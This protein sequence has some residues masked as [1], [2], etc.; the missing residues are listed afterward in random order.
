MGNGGIQY[1]FD[2]EPRHAM[3]AG[4]QCYIRGPSDHFPDFNIGIARSF[5]SVHFAWRDFVE[6]YSRNYLVN[7]LVYGAH[8]D[9]FFNKG[10]GDGD[11]A[12]RKGFGGGD[13]EK[14]H[15][16]NDFAHLCNAQPGSNPAVHFDGS[17]QLDRDIRNDRFDRT[18]Y[19]ASRLSDRRD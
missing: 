4:F 15:A 1:I 8:H 3:G 6:G 19:S 11:R 2:S 16:A 18:L 13:F 7:G 10:N 9:A 14:P 17:Y 5:L 12:G